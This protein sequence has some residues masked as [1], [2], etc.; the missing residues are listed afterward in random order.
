MKKITQIDREVKKI[1]GKD[2]STFIEIGGLIV[3]ILII[4]LI[5][6]GK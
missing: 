3:G 4:I 1:V 5:L 6:F 2:K